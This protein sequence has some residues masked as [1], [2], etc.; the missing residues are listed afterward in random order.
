MFDSI[1]G[2]L[3]GAMPTTLVWIATIAVVAALA[4]TGTKLLVSTL[5]C[6]AWL[7]LIGTPLW[8]MIVLAVP[9]VVLNVAPLRRALVTQRVLHLIRSKGMLPAVS[10]TERTAI[11]AGT[12]WIDKDLFSGRPDFRRL[13]REPYPGLSAEEQAFMDGPVEE[14]CHLT[15]D[16]QVWKQRDLPTEVWDFLKVNRFF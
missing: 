15:D 5:V 2:A 1:H 13:L 11:E 7:W 9:A 10:E 8:L 3:S 12:V 6:A 4:F 16:W 14:V